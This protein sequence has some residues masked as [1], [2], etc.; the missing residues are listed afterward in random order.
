MTPP[1]GEGRRPEAG[2]V[3][4]SA[5]HRRTLRRRRRSRRA[6]H[7]SST[8]RYRPTDQNPEGSMGGIPGSPA[9]SVSGRRRRGGRSPPPPAATTAA[10]SAISRTAPEGPTRI[11]RDQW[12]GYR[13]ARQGHR[14]T[15]CPACGRARPPRPPDRAPSLGNYATDEP[16]GP[17]GQPLTGGTGPFRMS[18]PPQCSHTLTAAVE[19]PIP[20]GSQQHRR[21]V[22]RDPA[23]QAPVA[24]RVAPSDWQSTGKP[25]PAHSEGSRQTSRES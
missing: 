14:P 19:G 21:G 16:Q 9:R 12:G 24:P 6:L 3:R 4:A 25:A 8:R 18:T 10:P 23:P 1:A 13:A 2:H 5:T 7:R 11:R 15:G 17:A 20:R 22:R